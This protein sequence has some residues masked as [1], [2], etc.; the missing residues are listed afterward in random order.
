MVPSSSGW[1]G[2]EFSPPAI[3][4][5]ITR[6]VS[7]SLSAVRPPEEETPFADGRL[8]ALALCLNEGLGVRHEVICAL[9]ALEANDP[10]EKPVVCRSQLSEVLLAEGPSYAPVQLSL[11][12]I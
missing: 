11:I 12:H 7:R 4:P 10:Q 2:P 1:P 6:R 5:N 3:V 8:D 9:S